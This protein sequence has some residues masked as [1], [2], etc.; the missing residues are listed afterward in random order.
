MSGLEAASVRDVLRA[1]WVPVLAAIAAVALFVSAGNWQ[2]RRMAEKERLRTQLDAAAR[3]APVPLPSLATAAEWEAWRYR[4]VRLDGEFD[5]DRQI[6]IDNRVHAGRAG[7]HV[8]APLRLRD[9]RAVLVN[10]GW[11]AQGPTRSA[12]PS[13]P[14]PAGRVGVL[15]RINIPASGYLELDR[16]TPAGALWQN[17]DPSRYVAAT[18]LAVLPIVVEESASGADP[19]GLVRD[20]PVPDFGVDKHRGYRLQWYALAALTVGLTL[21]FLLR[22][23]RLRTTAS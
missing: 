14:P 21:F 18:G 23:R 7:F 4:P 13:A 11:I 17:L 2:G 20:W 5:A 19:G 15:G 16:G 9:G 6:Y 12:L 3:V 22:R 10:R 8:V 1:P